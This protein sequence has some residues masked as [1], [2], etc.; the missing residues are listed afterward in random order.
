MSIGYLRTVGTLLT[1]R[2][3]LPRSSAALVGY[4]EPGR[5]D[6]DRP[7]RTGS[8]GPTRPVATAARKAEAQAKLA[9]KARAAQQAVQV[10]AAFAKAM[11]SKVIPN[12]RP[13]DQWALN[14]ALS[15]RPRP[16]TIPNRS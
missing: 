1:T 7:R 9:N 3:S 5:L 15:G 13:S 2:P 14:N 8:V 6:R 16:E 12:L 11:T 4:L 10:D